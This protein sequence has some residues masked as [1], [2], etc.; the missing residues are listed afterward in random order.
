ML[1]K[2]L[3]SIILLTM[4]TCNNQLFAQPDLEWEKNYGG[5]E[6]DRARMIKQTTD[7]GYIIIGA[8][9]SSDGDVGTNNGN[10]DCWVIK[11]DAL[12]N[13]EWEQSYGGTNWDYSR[14]IQQTIDGGYIVAG[15]SLSSDGDVGSNYGESDFWV[16]KLDETG[17]IEWE[18]NYGGSLTD[19]ANAILQTADG[20]Y[21]VAGESNSDD[22]EVGNNYGSY[23]CWVL[24]LD[25]IGNLE[26]AKTYGGT[27]QEFV[28]SL[29]QADDG[30]YLVGTSSQSADNDV[31]G[32][33]GEEDFWIFKLD[34]LGNIEWQ[35][36][37]GGNCDQSLSSMIVANDGGYIA[38]GDFCSYDGLDS[39]LTNGSYDIWVLKISE[40]GSI[41]WE[42]NFGGTESD[43]HSYI[44]NTNDNGFVVGCSSQ[45]ND[46]DVGSN[47][48][49][50]DFWVFKLDGSGNMEWEQNY[51][52]SQWDLVKSIEQA[53]DGGFV[54]AGSS[55]SSDGSVSD[56]NGDFDYWVVKLRPL[57][58]GINTIDLNHNV[59]IFPNPSIGSF[60]INSKDISDSVNIEIVNIF[61][62]I[63][64]SK[65]QKIDIPIQINHLPKGIYYVSISSP[66][67][68]L[69]KKIIL[70]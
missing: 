62:A 69:V 35:Q 6:S 51:G 64:Y 48:G 58:V 70:R 31:G 21:L 2:Y 59:S 42:E 4:L 5:T 53:S 16:F 23:D 52:G 26:W 40:T 57:N 43:R 17:N 56:N 33:N 36:N 54:I 66:K 8:S 15:S 44:Q 20:G 65:T 9:N 41:E 60:M 7:G 27:D 49:E 25:M 18:K 63:A 29:L 46:I 32:N 34:T 22:G 45:S 11:L 67:L 1:C 68:N 30:G 13:I 14:D 19:Q 38:T 55:R 3:I 39:T 61:G 24:K 28:E 12:G 47:Y 50:L 37:Y 10:K